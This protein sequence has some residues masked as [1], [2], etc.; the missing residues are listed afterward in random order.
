M[1]A[2]IGLTVVGGAI[3]KI[4]LPE[5]DMQASIPWDEM[6][7]QAGITFLAAGTI[8]ALHTWIAL[9][10]GS[11]VIASAIGIGMTIAGLVLG[12]LEWTEFFPWSMP[13]TTLHQYYEGGAIARYLA[14]GF[15]SWLVLSLL[16]N[17]DV[18]RLEI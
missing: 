4:I 10:S 16:G 13:A 5:L 6:F 14:V 15:I 18:K 7:R 9:R 12:G 1:L 11:F 2:L 3:L 17:W 8:L